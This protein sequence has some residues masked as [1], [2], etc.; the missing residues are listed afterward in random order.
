MS[1]AENAHPSGDT[2]GSQPSNR[3]DRR[4]PP[5]VIGIT[6]G[7]ASGKSAVAAL[8]EDCGLVRLDADAVAREATDRPE[9]RAGLRQRFGAIVPPLPEPLDR[10]ALAKAAFGDPEARADL[11]ALT[12]PA[13][14]A[15]LLAGLAEAQAAGRS[16][17]LDVP[18]LLEGGLV[19]RCDEVVFVDTPDAT[20]D[21]RARARGWEP[22]ELTRREAAQLPL[23]VKR[24]RATATIDNSS[25]LEHAARQ[26]ERLLQSF[27]AARRPSPERPDPAGP[28]PHAAPLPPS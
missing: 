15:K 28:A 19:S 4:L 12:H 10:A 24:A 25:T 18:L 8:F 27:R 7:I 11:D 2:P 23:P 22:D 9:V 1:L 17:I 6:G 3:S 20:R 14:R 5:L 16:V 13:I 26:V 21:A